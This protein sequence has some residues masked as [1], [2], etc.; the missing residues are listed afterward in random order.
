M[1]PNPPG[2]P[3]GRPLH[4]A[5]GLVLRRTRHE[6]ALSQEQLADQSDLHRNHIGRI[7]RGELAPTLRT[8]ETIAAALQIAPSTLI[9]QAELETTQ[10]R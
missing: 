8:L 6:R 10:T 4:I 3:A 5:F 7:E 9:A 1:R 2:A